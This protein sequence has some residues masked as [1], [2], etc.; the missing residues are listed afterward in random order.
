MG[1][2][3]EGKL[4][5]VFYMLDSGGCGHPMIDKDGNHTQ[6]AP[7]TNIIK[8]SRGFDADQI[9]W[10]TDSI[11]EIHALDSDVKISFADWIYFYLK[12]KAPS[13]ITW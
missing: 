12:Q 4:L 9:E 5:R 6:P 8:T 13:Y 3:Q 7:G 2:E 10:Y 11:N 1:I